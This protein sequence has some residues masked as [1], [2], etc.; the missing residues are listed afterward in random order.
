NVVLLERP[1]NAE[2]LVSAVRSAQRARSRQHQMRLQLE[3]QERAGRMKD[4]FLA[5]LSHELR[6]PLSAILGWVHLLKVRAAG[7]PPLLK[8][9]DTIERNARAQARLIEELLD[10]SRINAG[11]MTLELK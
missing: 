2:T 7:Q 8:G 11:N 10:M 4:E 3:E 5:T 9:V 1:L 6:T